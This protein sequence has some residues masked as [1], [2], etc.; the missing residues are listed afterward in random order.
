[1]RSSDSRASE[2][3]R[4]MVLTP[5]GTAAIAVVRLFG[6][7]VRPFLA[8]H[9]SRPV[10]PGR[11]IHGNLT[12]GGRVV[13]DPVVVVADDV[14][15]ADIS[16]HGGTWVVR[17]VMELAKHSG[18]EVAPASPVPLPLDAVDGEDLLEREMLAWIPAAKTE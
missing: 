5:P 18:F 11:P 14:S 8:E 9:F 7:G 6:D 4:A 10:A 15:W 1:M 13:D 3:N 2:R 12:D 17:E 16:L